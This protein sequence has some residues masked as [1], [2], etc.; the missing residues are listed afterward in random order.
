MRTRVISTNWRETRAGRFVMCVD[1]SAESGRS[2]EGEREKEKRREREEKEEGKASIGKKGKAPS[3]FSALSFFRRFPSLRSFAGLPLPGLRDDAA[4][5]DYHVR[6]Q[7]R[8]K[9][10]HKQASA[11]LA[12]RELLQRERESKG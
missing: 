12:C 3:I 5:E 7:E 1:R 9:I 2:G 10:K 4:R 8:R 6:G 11:P